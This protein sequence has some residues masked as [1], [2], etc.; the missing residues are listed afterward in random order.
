[1]ILLLHHSRLQISRDG[2][3]ANRMEM[4]EGHKEDEPTDG[5]C[6]LDMCAHNAQ[7]SNQRSHLCF[8]MSYSKAESIVAC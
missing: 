6:F 8:R 7:A 1:M 3:K 4:A 5:E 2:L